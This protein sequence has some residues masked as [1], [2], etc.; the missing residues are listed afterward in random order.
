M[1]GYQVDQLTNLLESDGFRWMIKCRGGSEGQTKFSTWSWAPVKKSTLIVNVTREW[2]RKQ[3][4]KHTSN[5]VFS[6]SGSCH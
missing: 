1:C 3:R 6:E 5:V 2:T 4:A